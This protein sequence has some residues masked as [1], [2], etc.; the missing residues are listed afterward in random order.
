MGMQDDAD[1]TILAWVEEVRVAQRSLLVHSGC[2]GVAH[3]HSNWST[4]VY[5]RPLGLW[6]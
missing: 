5:A 3:G 4:Q 1:A 6:A 2:G